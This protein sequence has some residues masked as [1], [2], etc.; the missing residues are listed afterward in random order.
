MFP[1]RPALFTIKQ[2]AFH[3]RQVLLT[4]KQNTLPK[5][6]TLLRIKQETIPQRCALFTIKEQL[7]SRSP[8]LLAVVVLSRLAV[9]T[10]NAAYRTRVVMWAFFWV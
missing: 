8:E 5:R 9:T 6:R 3:K 7:F 10:Y 1:E 4:I 2:E